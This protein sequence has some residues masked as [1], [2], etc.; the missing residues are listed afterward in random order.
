MLEIICDVYIS[1]QLH[2]HF[3]NLNWQGTTPSA[4]ANTSSAVDDVPV[5]AC[6]FGT[7]F[8]LTVAKLFA[9][10]VRENLANSDGLTCDE[11]TKDYDV[12]RKKT[13]VQH[14]ALTVAKGKAGL[15]PQAREPV[16]D[17]HSEKMF[18]EQ[19]NQQ[20]PEETMEGCY[21]Q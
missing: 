6:L 4:A 20:I 21:V 18:D 10:I 12:T 9:R 1:G 5:L 3:D 16:Q 19:A 17:L 11:A 7:V 8:Q 15:S 13:P 2:S 14:D